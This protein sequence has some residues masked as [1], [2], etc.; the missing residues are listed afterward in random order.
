MLE[1]KAILNENPVVM[2][3]MAG[4]TDRPARLIARTFGCGLVYTEMIS[5]KAL[6]YQN[7]KTFALMNM[8][9]EQ[10]PVSM[11]IFGSE[12]EIMAEGARIMEAHGAQII[13]INMGCPV[14][15]VV[16]HQEGSALMREPVLASKIVEA[17]VQAVK[18][19]V[20]VKIRKGW[21]E[22]QINAVEFA[23][24]MENSGAQA[25]AVHG[26]TRSQFYSGAADW[27]IIAKV[28]AAVQIPVIGNGDIFSP[29]D[30]LAM[31]QQ[32]GCDG[33]MIGR[34]ALGHPWLYQQTIDFL[35]KGSYA[36]E[37]DFAER[38]KILLHHAA[39]ACTEKGEWIAIREMRK[40]V[41][42]YFKGM[43]HSARLREKSNTIATMED[44]RNLLTQAIEC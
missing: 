38:T 9:G 21:D 17:M 12:P 2:A 11:Q 39:L 7:E 41:A 20:T 24:R 44:L 4:I 40:H 30:G 15:K 27:E 6:T 33:I 32:T 18:V 14:P 26:R 13:D 8:E 5:A 16:N 3:P 37:P 29:E 36:P 19:P 31:L 35:Q 25:V 1:M 42:W 34:G 23:K 10:Q 28:K 43:P 22:T